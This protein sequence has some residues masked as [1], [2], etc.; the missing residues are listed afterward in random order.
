MDEFDRKTF[1]KMVEIGEF[2]NGFKFKLNKSKGD[3]PWKLKESASPKVFE[4]L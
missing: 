1:M 2:V 4:K 3:L